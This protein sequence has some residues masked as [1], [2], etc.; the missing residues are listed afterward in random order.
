MAGEHSVDVFGPEQVGPAALAGW[1]KAPGGDQVSDRGGRLV[2]GVDGGFGG[3]QV[4]RFGGGRSGWRPSTW[5]PSRTSRILSV[6]HD[7]D[8]VRRSR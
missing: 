3:R 2:A 4:G 6:T 5:R 8:L 1:P 7:L